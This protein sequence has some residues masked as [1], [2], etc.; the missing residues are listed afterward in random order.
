MRVACYGPHGCSTHS[1]FVLHLGEFSAFMVSG[2]QACSVSQGKILLHLSRLLDSNIT[3]RNGLCEWR[4]GF[5]FFIH[6]TSHGG[7]RGPWTSVSSD[8]F[9]QDVLKELSTSKVVGS[10]S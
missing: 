6:P 8:R 1:G 5:A 7:T 9:H 2:K 4:V 10:L 3:V